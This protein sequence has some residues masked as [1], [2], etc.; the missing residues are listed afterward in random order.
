[1]NGHFTHGR[2]VFPAFSA[3]NDSIPL[4]KG[5][6]VKWPGISSTTQGS[7][8]DL[9]SDSPYFARKNEIIA[10]VLSQLTIGAG[11]NP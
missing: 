1:M 3:G 9:W 4:A 7:Y 5:E 8:T 10:G 6:E 2:E 11:Q